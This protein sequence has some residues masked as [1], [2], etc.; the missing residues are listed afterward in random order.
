MP[1]TVCPARPGFRTITTMNND[2]A[3]PPVAI[4][5]E[6]LALLQAA[7]TDARVLA[8]EGS[9]ELGRYVL[10]QGFRRVLGMEEVA[11]KKSLLREWAREVLRFDADA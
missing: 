3:T 7:N 11:W 2:P 5:A 4:P 8:R 6:E 10:I 1:F 9:R